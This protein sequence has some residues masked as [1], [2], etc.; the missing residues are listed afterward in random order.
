MSGTRFARL[1]WSVALAG[2][3]LALLIVWR[4]P[5]QAVVVLA[6]TLAVG[7]L[8]A[9][10]AVQDLKTFTISDSAI[11]TIAILAVA[12][13]WSAATPSGDSVLETSLATGVDAILPGGMLL[14]FREVYY[15]RKGFDGLGLGDVKLAAA[16]GLLV[17]AAGFSWALFAASL[18]A[19]AFVA[20][21]RL[22]AKGDHSGAP[23]AS[24]DKLAFGAL[25]APALWTVWI[26][27]QAPLL[28][29]YAER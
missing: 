6:V 7:A 19:L 14:L 22:L 21:G 26:A 16:G 9:W 15:R 10:I 18:L 17:G 2:L 12:Y 25:L 24:S 13:R 20:A 28:L 1:E 29:P 23:L 3:G 8:A 4:A 5:S 11:L 27:Q